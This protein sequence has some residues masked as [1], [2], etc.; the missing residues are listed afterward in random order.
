MKVLLIYIENN[1]NTADRIKLF[2]DRKGISMEAFVLK[3]RED[4]GID[5][6]MCL[7]PNLGIGEK[8]QDPTDVPTHVL[9]VSPLSRS[10]FDFLAG[11]AYGSSVPF[12]ICGET[13]IAGIPKQA[14][15]LFTSFLT[16]DS[17]EKHFENECEVYKK[18]EEARKIIRAQE[19]LLR[20][21]LPLTRESLAQCSAEGGVKE[22]SLFLAAGFSPD[23]RNA[24]GVPILNIS[25]RKGNFDVFRYLIS[26][27]AQLNLPS[28]DRGCTALIDSVMCNNNDMVAELVSAGAE[29]DI[30][31][32]AGQ[33]ALV[34]AVGAGNEKI[35][36][37]LLRAGANPDIPDS[38]GVS[39]R[40]YA[41]LFHKSS[42]TSLFEV[43]SPLKG[44]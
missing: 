18:Q 44:V 30:K 27:G 25:A 42:I 38:M 15:F 11:F 10:W 7:F 13:A 9:V 43:L 20:M 34:I 32:K 29:L 21:G 8:D 41:A 2:L 22:V 6:F 26:A 12:L 37:A 35:V 1:K 14:A 40:K 31:S 17:L 3:T 4:E 19:A 36:E 24:A 23:S 16:E 39:A 33:T 5:R 28:E